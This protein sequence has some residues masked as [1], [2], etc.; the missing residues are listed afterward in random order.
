MGKERM[1]LALYPDPKGDYFIFRMDEE[2]NIGAFDINK[3][4]SEYM[5]D[6]KLEHKGQPIYLTGKELLKYKQ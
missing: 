2:V 1:Q 3:A 6:H 5:I 4:V